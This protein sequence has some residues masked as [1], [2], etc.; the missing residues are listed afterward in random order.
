MDYEKAI[1]VFKKRFPKHTVT[2]CID[3]AKDYYVLEAV[4]DVNSTDYNLPYYAV[5]KTDDTIT[6]FIPTYDLDAF[7]DAVRNRTVYLAR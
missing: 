1:A 4:E 6:S 5:S 7:F 3:Y 2:R